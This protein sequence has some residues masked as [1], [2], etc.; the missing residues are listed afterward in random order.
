MSLA[1]VV[2]SILFS[3]S[4]LVFFPSPNELVWDRILLFLISLA[5]LIYTYKKD[6]SPSS[7]GKFLTVVY[8]AHATQCVLAVA[9]NDFK[10]SYLLVLFITAQVSAYSFRR[11]FDALVYLIYINVISAGALC[12]LPS[13]PHEQKLLYIFFILISSILQFF[14]TK[15]KCRFVSNMKM[16]EH[17]LKSLVA[18]TED[19][20]FITD[21]VGTILDLNP[22]AEEM[23][24]YS[25]QNFLSKDFEILRKNN[26]TPNEISE[27]LESLEKDNFWISQ[28]TLVKANGVEFPARIAVALLESGGRRYLIYRVQDITEIKEYETLLLEAKEKAELAAIAKSQ[29]LAVMSHEIRTPLNGVIATV[30]LLQQSEMNR[31]QSEL[32]DTIMKSGQSLMMLINDILEFSKMESGKMQLDPRPCSLSEVVFDVAD[33]LRPHAVIKG[34]DIEVNFDSKIPRG[35]ILDD[36]RLRQ[37]L[38]N[39]MGNAIK[40]TNEGKISIICESDEVLH[41]KSRI[42]FKI[43]DTGIGIPPEKQHLLF[44][45]FSQMDASTSRKY[46]GTGLGLAISKQLIELMGGQVTIES[47]VGRGTTFSFAFWCE[48]V[49]PASDKKSQNDAR[50]NQNIEEGILKE[51]KILVAEDNL[52]NKQVLKFMLDK[53]HLDA[54]FAE[55]GLGVLELCGKKN[56]DIIFMDMQMPEMDGVEA[57]VTLRKG[58]GHQSIIVGISA[59]A[60]SED[61]LKCEQAGMNDF[62]PK[63]FDLHQLKDIIVRWQQIALQNAHSAA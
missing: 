10:V 25:F 39:L 28:T 20:I 11:E 43:S 21:I 27:G 19:S 13:I 46:G 40:F 17:L 55:N 53:L 31:E 35:L 62:L 3:L 23:F 18:K 51:L 9:L 56:Y 42:K 12:L 50:K 49:D 47:E 57:T 4:F 29:F 30:S 48:E 2:A 60:Y 16:N 38:L 36:H 45:S 14:V 44:Q 33:L 6:V 59:N 24:G 7:S 63:P 26:L 22:K 61:K 1:G 34:L 54:D 41:N 15:V 52:V 5:S 58:Q 37:V 8:Y 32:A